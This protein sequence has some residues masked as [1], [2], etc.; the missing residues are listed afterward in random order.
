MEIEMKTTHLREE[1]LK[2]NKLDCMICLKSIRSIKFLTIRFVYAI[3]YRCSIG[4]GALS[5]KDFEILRDSNVSGL[6]P[7]PFKTRWWLHNNSLEWTWPLDSQYV[8]SYWCARH[9][10]QPNS[11]FEIRVHNVWVATLTLG[12]TW[13]FDSRYRISSKGKR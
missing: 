10:H 13:P 8:V 9:C 6:W 4:T 11:V 1:T 12:V 2:Y 3:S 7:W 5:P